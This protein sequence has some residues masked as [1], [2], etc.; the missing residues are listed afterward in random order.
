MI[1][2]IDDQVIN[3]YKRMINIGELYSKDA[4]DIR[5]DIEALVKVIEEL[6]ASGEQITMAINEVSTAISESATGIGFIAEQS[7]IIVQKVN[8]INDN[9]KVLSE[10]NEAIERTISNFKA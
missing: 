6:A 8:T 1:E 4:N 9:M 5:A 3:D 10:R 2:F 7:A